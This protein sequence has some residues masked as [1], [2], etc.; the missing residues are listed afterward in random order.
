MGH[1][2]RVAL[3]VAGDDVRGRVRAGVEG[4]EEAGLRVGADGPVA[5]ERRADPVLLVVRGH[6]DVQAQG[7]P[8]GEGRWLTGAQRTRWRRR[9]GASA[10]PPA[11]RTW[12]SI[13]LAG[14]SVARGL[15]P[16]SQTTTP[17]AG[18]VALV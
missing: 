17:E 6:D 12:G 10:A 2:A 13:P 14:G 18:G 4:D 7:D 11:T 1:D 15:V 3:G 5:V 16:R 9:A 8:P